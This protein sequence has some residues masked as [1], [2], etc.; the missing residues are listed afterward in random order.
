MKQGQGP[1]QRFRRDIKF[2]V[3]PIVEAGLRFGQLRQGRVV[4]GGAEGVRDRSANNRQSGTRERP[5]FQIGEGMN[6][7][8]GGAHGQTQQ[9]ALREGERARFYG[10]AWRSWVDSNSATKS[11]KRRAGA[12]CSLAA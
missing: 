4:H 10:C 8:R 11:A 6:R 5:L 7:L 2:K 9:S 12:S 3:M 1:G